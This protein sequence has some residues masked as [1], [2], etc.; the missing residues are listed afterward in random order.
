MFRMLH[1]AKVEVRLLNRRV[2]SE[3]NFRGFSTSCSLV[4]NV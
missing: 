1:Q 3:M 2:S 4:S